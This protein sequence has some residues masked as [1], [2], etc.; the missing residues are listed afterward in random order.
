MGNKKT[1]RVDEKALLFAV[2]ILLAV[3]VVGS[4]FVIKP[5]LT[6]YAI[7]EGYNQTECGD[8]GYVWEDI[9]N[10]T[11]IDIP[12]P[13]CVECEVGCVEEYTETLCEEGCE[14]DCEGN[15]TCVECEVGCVEEY[16]EELCEEDC[17]ES[18]CVYEVIGGQCTGDV[19]DVDN[20]NLCLDETTCVDA[21][22]YW[23]DD[24][25]NADEECV[26]DTCGSSCGDISDGCGGTLDC[27]SCVSEDTSSEDDYSC[28]DG[29]CHAAEDCTSCPNDC[30]E[31]PTLEE[32]GDITGAVVQICTPN[33][34][35]DSWSECAEESQS[36]S[37]TDTNGCDSEAGKPELTQS[38]VIPETC[39]DGIQNQDE[40]GIDCGGV[41]EGGCSFFTMMGNAV[42][43]PINSSRQFIKDNKAISFSLLGMI[44]LAVSWIVCVKV[45]LKKDNIFFFLKDF[46][47]PSNFSFL[48][49]NKKVGP[50]N[51]NLGS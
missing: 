24:I 50:N 34:E 48:Q 41:C 20:L 2:F 21:T 18:C 26:L 39:S 5:K 46:H 3:L 38:C 49:R 19:C 35:C 51:S 11:C 15:M 42:N 14:L 31:C 30:G 12:E 33:W 29:D 22:G 47:L 23:Y 36:R 45:F 9:L 6:G 1:K 17:L 8:A 32:E 43:V 4:L 10:D 40:K 28:G 44:V 37:C 13:D 16:T 25:C 7:I 27:G